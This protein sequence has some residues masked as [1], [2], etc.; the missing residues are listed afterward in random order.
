MCRQRAAIR[1][2]RCQ[3]YA[4]FLPGCDGRS[5]GHMGSYGNELQAIKKLRALERVTKWAGRT[6]TH[7]R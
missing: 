4:V 5:D 1:C 7:T 3:N 6:A 2:P